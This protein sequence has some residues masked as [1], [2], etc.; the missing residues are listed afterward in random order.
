M[1]ELFC[2]ILG[3][4]HFGKNIRNWRELSKVADLV[5]YPIYKPNFNYSLHNRDNVL[6]HLILTAFLPDLLIGYNNFSV[7]H[8]DLNKFVVLLF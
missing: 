8:V 7:K 3:G 2:G 1:T 4:S 5:S 6:L